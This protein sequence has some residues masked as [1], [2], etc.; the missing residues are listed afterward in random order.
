MRLFVCVVV[1]LAVLFSEVTDARVL[2]SKS[3]RVTAR[4]ESDDVSGEAAAETALEEG[5]EEGGEEAAAAAAEGEVVEELP[6]HESEEEEEQLQDIPV[7]LDKAALREEELR[8][9]YHIYGQSYSSVFPGVPTNV[10]IRINYLCANYDEKTH[11]LSSRVWEQLRWRDERLT[12]DPKDFG[13]ISELRLPGYYLWHPDIKL[14][15]S[16]EGSWK[17]WVNALLYSSGDILWIP[18]ITYKSFCSP[19]GKST[20]S[21]KLTLGSWTYDGNMLPLVEADSSDLFATDYYDSACPY[22]VEKS[23]AAVNVQHYECCEEPYPSLDIEFTIRE[24]N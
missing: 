12:W 3:H 2:V 8:L 11:I 18:P 23:K 17:D 15:N 21:C 10:S 20:A 13:G 14:Y 1:V 16:A 19:T 6:G 9:L 5:L 7:E 22:S 4:Q 24:N